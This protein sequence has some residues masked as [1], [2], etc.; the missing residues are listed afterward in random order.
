MYYSP[1]CRFEY[2]TGD[3]LPPF[4]ALVAPEYVSVAN[5][6]FLERLFPTPPNDPL[7]QKPFTWLLIAAALERAN[8]EDVAAAVR[9][10]EL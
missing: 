8:P 4:G 5:S 7:D 3:L 1:G 2:G 10:S 6:N 9:V